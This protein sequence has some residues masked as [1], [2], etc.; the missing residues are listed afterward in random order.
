MKKFLALLLALVMV[1]SLVAC[2]APKNDDTQDA[3]DQQQ[4]DTIPQDGE[5]NDAEDT[6]PAADSEDDYTFDIK[7]DDHTV[8]IT[9]ANTIQVYTHDGA[10]V[11]GY[12]TYVDAGDAETAK[13][14]AKSI[15]LNDSYY[16]NM[17]IKSVTAKGTYVVQ[18]YD[19]EGFP[20]TTYEDLHY[21]A[22]QYKQIQQ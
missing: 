19:A 4:E 18:E 12:T 15:D 1:L 20:C 7:E 21:L 6:E 13:A 11:T 3:E 8:V 9:I 2:G 14:V 10:N 22:E 17:G 5:K 16:S